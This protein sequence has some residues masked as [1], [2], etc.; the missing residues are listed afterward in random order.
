[1][2]RIEAVYEQIS[3]PGPE[4]DLAAWKQAE[5]TVGDLVYPDPE[6]GHEEG[7]ETYVAETDEEYEAIQDMTNRLD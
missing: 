2:T 4:V 3:R 6:P 1:M 7:W 5:E